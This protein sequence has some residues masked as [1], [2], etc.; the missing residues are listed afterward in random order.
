MESL[1]IVGVLFIL[2]NDC[3]GVYRN[4][5]FER[6]LKEREECFRDLLEIASKH[7]NQLREQN[8]QSEIRLEEVKQMLPA[9]AEVQ[10]SNALAQVDFDRRLKNIEAHIEAIKMAS[11]RGR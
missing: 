1:V 10:N 5:R 8:S 2:I 7:R 9:L 4:F 6:K 11:I 3:M